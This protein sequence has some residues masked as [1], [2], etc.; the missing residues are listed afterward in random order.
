MTGVPRKKDHPLSPFFYPVTLSPVY[1]SSFLSET[2]GYPPMSWVT[3]TSPSYES[4]PMNS[5]IITSLLGP[6]LLRRS[7]YLFDP[8]SLKLHLICIFSFPVLT[9]PSPLF[10]LLTR[11]FL[12]VLYMSFL[13]WRP[14]F[15]VVELNNLDTSNIKQNSCYV[16]KF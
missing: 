9:E 1:R 6:L 15:I 10:H 7:I 13:S 8:S 12:P 4:I 5:S 11:D 14:F 16:C 2:L 3:P